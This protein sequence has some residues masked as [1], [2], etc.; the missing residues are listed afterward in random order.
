M[1]GRKVLPAL[2]PA[3]AR[4]GRLLQL[5]YLVTNRCNLRCP[6]CFRP[7]GEDT[8]AEELTPAEVARLAPR[9]GRPYWLLIGGGEPFL[10][11]DLS[12]LCRALLKGARPAVLTIASN[13]S[14]PEEALRQT[15]AIIGHAR[16]TLVVVKLSLDGAGAR[17]DE[18][19]RWP[20]G[21]A[22]V[23]ET[24][25]LLR[26]LARGR[27]NLELGFNSVLTPQSLAG[28]PGLLALVAGLP[29]RPAHTLSL[30]RG[31]RT[32]AGCKAVAPDD[33]LAAVR[34]LEAQARAT[35]AGRYRFRGAG[36]KA[37]L[38]EALHRLVHQ[39]LRTG[40]QPLPCL[41]GRRALVIEPDGEARACEVLEGPAGG[42]GG[43]REH[44]LDLGRLLASP[45]ARA[46]A[47]AIAA[48]GCSCTH[49]CNL[50]VNLV[51][52][53]RLLPALARGLFQR[54]DASA[55]A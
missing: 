39:A 47:A 10:R 11:P 8:R 41:A 19:R 26:G 34:R 44:G 43:L 28:L 4:P 54:G 40:R 21:Q 24:Y 22:R 16:G 25:E 51:A 36:V 35:G 50:L 1:A 33:Y 18:L 6:F 49:E 3:L 9:L 55:G 20:G 12:E 15:R 23:M 37:L 13:G 17:H 5:T 46:T 45:R 30:A 2:L 7:P 27:A 53:P 14:L 29:G 52:G 31:A 42:L 38:D 48:G 32:P